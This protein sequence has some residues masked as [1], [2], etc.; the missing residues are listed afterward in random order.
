MS[1]K[2]IDAVIVGADRIARNGDVAN[3]IGTYNLAIL[4]KAH[5]IDFF[6][7]APISTFDPRLK[8][9]DE[10]PIEERAA[11]EVK[12]IMG[13]LKIASDEVTVYSPAFDVTPH[14]MVT[15]IITERG[16][17]RPPNEKEIK[18]VMNSVASKTT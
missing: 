8:T 4:A 11:E 3:K 6:V 18:K 5:N 15:A 7:V 12:N 10:I 1:K 9:G 2:R 17:I 13:R 14:T 16:I